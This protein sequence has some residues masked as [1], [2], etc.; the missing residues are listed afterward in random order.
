MKIQCSVLALDQSTKK[1]GW[2]CFDGTSLYKWGLIDVPQSVPAESRMIEAL[3]QYELLVQ[4]YHPQLVVI[5]DV[6]LRKSPRTLILLARLQGMI[7]GLCDRYRIP[8]KIVAPATWRD[9]L[10]FDQGRG[11]KTPDLKKQAIDFVRDSYGLKVGDDICESI[12]IGL[13]HLKS[14][15]ALPN[16]DELHRK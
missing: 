4:K 5:E 8:I 6:Q 2:S 7:I 15:G 16:L 12:C 13:A 11:I 1:S 10:G 3:H 9:E 14:I